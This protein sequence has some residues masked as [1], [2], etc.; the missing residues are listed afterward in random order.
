[1][2]K[3]PTSETASTIFQVFTIALMAIF[4]ALSVVRGL[5]MMM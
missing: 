3:L 2:N 4:S 5:G 1:M